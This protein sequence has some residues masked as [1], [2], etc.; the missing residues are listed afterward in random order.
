M[1]TT[2]AAAGIPGQGAELAASAAGLLLAALAVMASPGPTTM[3]VVAVGAAFGFR[4]ALPYLAAV[5]A[6]TILVLLALAGGITT[7]LQAMPGLAPVLAAASTLYLLWLAWRIAT[8]PPLGAEGARAVPTPAGGLLLALANPKAWLALG[9]VV[10]GHRLALAPPM[11]EVAVRIAVLSTL[12]VL[13]HL[14]WLAAGA[15]VA[16]RL[17]RPRTARI[18]NALLAVALVAAAVAGFAGGT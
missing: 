18:V 5:S 2:L 12:V 3:S 17:R 13:V 7:A 16:R 6:G 8:A 14:A 11:V 15:A 9:A 1:D 4:G 10:A